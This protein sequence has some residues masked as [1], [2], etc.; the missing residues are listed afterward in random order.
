LLWV[1]FGAA[2]V[3]FVLL[4]FISAPYGRYNRTGWGPTVQARAAWI[5]M[6]LPAVLVIA[7]LFFLH[8]DSAS[9]LSVIFLAIWQVHYL[10]RTFVYPL[11]I[12]GA[13]KPFPI[14]L[15]AMAF[16]FNV[17]NGYIICPLHRCQPHAPGLRQPPLVPHTLPPL[18]QRTQDPDPPPLLTVPCHKARA[19]GSGRGTRIFS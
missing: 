8:L 13:K 5:V 3:V 4:F 17:L 12:R 9:P 18:P 19:I 7:V 16:I 15:I 10:Y 6:E 1:E 14:L 2:A 11:R